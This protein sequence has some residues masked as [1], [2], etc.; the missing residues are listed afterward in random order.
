MNTFK[1]RLLA[2]FTIL[3]VVMVALPSFAPANTAFAQGDGDS[4]DP[5]EVTAVFEGEV[6]YL[7]D[8][9]VV[10]LVASEDS[11]GGLIVYLDEAEL[12]GLAVGDYVAAEGTLNEDG[13]VDATV[14]LPIEP[15]EDDTDPV[16]GDFMVIAGEVEQLDGDIIIGGYVIAPAGSFNPSGLEIGD[17]VI[18][19]GFLLNEDTIQATYLMVVEDLDD[20]DECDEEAE[21]DCDD[22]EEDECEVD[23]GEDGDADNDDGEDG[24]VDDSCADEEE[25]DEDENEDDRGVCTNLN[26]VGETLADEFEVDE[27]TI[28]EWRCDGYGYGEIARALLL[29]EE[30]GE[31]AAD[32]LARRA[33]GEGWGKILKDYDIHPSEL[34]PG[35]RISNGKGRPDSDD[36]S[37]SSKSKD[38]KK[39]K[40]SKSNNGRGNGR[41]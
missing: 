7:G 15:P 40:K 33:D 9:Y 11:E 12:A 25:D 19:T 39:N 17:V 18:L 23:D 10:L 32:I 22:E 4:E 20:E 21:E 28:L 38:K 31:D 29:A 41:D 35:R 3:L 16:A 26:P 27:D 8:G 30:A 13:S 24:D 34:A 37:S 36:D 6:L 5:P 14:V 1:S 2:I